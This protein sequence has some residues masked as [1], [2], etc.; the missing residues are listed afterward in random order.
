[1]WRLILS[2]TF[3]NAAIALTAGQLAFAGDKDNY[4]VSSPVSHKNLSI[5]F[6]H[7]TSKQGPV[8]LTLQEAMKMDAVQVH[9]TG[10]VSRLAI[11]NTSDREVFIQSGDIVKGGKQDRV[12]TVSLILP[13]KS[14]RI[15]ISALCVEQG[16]WQAR[17]KEDLK[18]FASSLMAVPSRE[19]KIAMKK[20]VAEA[21]DRASRTFGLSSRSSPGAFM[22][23]RQ[24]EVWDSVRKTQKLLSRSL[25]GNVASAA[26]PSSLQLALENDKLKQTESEYLQAFEEAGSKEG[27]IIGFVFAIN[28]KL[29]SADLYPS[30]ALFRKMWV[31]NLRASVMEA[32]AEKDNRAP[33]KPLAVEMVEAFLEPENRA[34]IKTTKVT[35]DVQL[36]TSDMDK[37]YYFDTRRKS[38]DWVHRNYLAKR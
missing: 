11:E 14:G 32:I 24:N 4:R 3:A 26:S 23:S 17:G 37:A 12:L 33:P 30:N 28:G 18:K 13:P 10:N 15:P 29:N 19:L 6:V 2:F 16:R 36:L 7:G 38:G 31:K 20:P 9:E 25:G 34:K 35:A 1:M 27:D 21:A 8:P 5:Y 22:A